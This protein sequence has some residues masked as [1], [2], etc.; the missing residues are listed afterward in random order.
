MLNEGIFD[1]RSNAKQAD[2]Q[3]QKNQ[4]TIIFQEMHHSSG[5]LNY[6][7]YEFRG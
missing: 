7:F 3:D 2:Q 5:Q 4:E 6:Q 1:E